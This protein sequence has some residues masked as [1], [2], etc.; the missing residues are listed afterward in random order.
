MAKKTRDLSR[1]LPAQKYKHSNPTELRLSFEFLGPGPK[2]IDLAKALSIIN[3]KAYS[4]QA[5]YYVSK[6]EYY[7]APAGSATSH[8]VDILTLPDTWVVKNAYRRAR[9]IYEHQVKIIDAPFSTGVSPAY[10]DFRVNLSDLHRSTGDTDPVLHDGAG[11]AT[12]HTADEWD[13]S[14]FVSARDD[15]G[16]SMT[17]DIFTAHMVGDHNVSATTNTQKRYTSVGIVKSY[18]ESRATV[19]T[20]SPN[21][22]NIAIDDPFL[23]MLNAS[24]EKQVEQIVNELRN[25]MDKP[26]YNSDL[27]VGEGVDLQQQLRLVTTADKGRVDAG[28]GFCA[29]LGLVMVDPDPTMQAPGGGNNGNSFRIVFTLAMG[30]YH[31]VYAERI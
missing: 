3:R 30:T 12:T 1:N 9:A 17:P 7:D 23:N 29:P 4:Q 2:F 14:G 24:T 21:E 22:D 27:Y 11:S 19:D 18:A 15:G 25:D 10:Y 5:Y 16:T 20:S 6:V 8:F 31:G 13:K 28:P 26:P